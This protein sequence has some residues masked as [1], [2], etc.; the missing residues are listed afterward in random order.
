MKSRYAVL[1]LAKE[2]DARFGE[3]AEIRR[4]IS[5]TRSLKCWIT[6][7]ERPSTQKA[8]RQKGMKCDLRRRSVVEPIIGHAK[9]EHLGPQYLAHIASDAINAV[10]A[11][12]TTTFS[13]RGGPGDSRI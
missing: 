11:A 6:L 4:R 13:F 12:S 2:F 3:R 9:G 8:T 7:M 5:A 10:L 1:R